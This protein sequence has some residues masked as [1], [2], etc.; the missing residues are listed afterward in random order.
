MEI[1]T[2]F[3]FGGLVEEGRENKYENW[4]RLN[5]RSVI[6]FSSTIS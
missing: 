1:D 4:L 2:L 5:K 3:P 6:G